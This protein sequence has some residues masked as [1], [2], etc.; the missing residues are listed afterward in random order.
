MGRR[1]LKLN[2]LRKILRSFGVEED[3]AAR[4]G[5]HTVFIRQFPEGTFTYPVPTHTKDVK[6]CYVKGCRKKFRLLPSDGVSDAE[7]FGRL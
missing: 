1:R 5:S 6:P 7:F 4:K 3:K 2:D